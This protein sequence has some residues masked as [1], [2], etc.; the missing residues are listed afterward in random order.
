MG[1]K[2]VNPLYLID[3]MKSP[4]YEIKIPEKQDIYSL[5]NRNFDKKKIILTIT[6][7]K[8]NVDI[9]NC[10]IKDIFINFKNNLE[11]FIQEKQTISNLN[12][13][14]NNITLFEFHK[15]IYIQN[16][17]LSYNK[18]TD[19]ILNINKKYILNSKKIRL[20]TF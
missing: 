19:E 9:I 15:K 13:S 18:I 1:N 2:F 7:P 17:N 12:L 6:I 5:Q 3:K 4:I 14:R 11:S 10:K 16:I 8:I 20:F